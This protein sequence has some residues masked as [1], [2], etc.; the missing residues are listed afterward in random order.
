MLPAALATIASGAA[1][2][3]PVED[4]YHGKTVT[5]YIGTTPGG[6]YDTYARLVA[7]FLGAHIPG[8]PVILPVNMPGA[9]GRTA[10]GH[11]Y[12][13]V[14]KDGLSLGSSDQALPLAQAVGDTTIKFDTSK[15]NWIGSTDSDNK[16]MVAWFTSGVKTIEDARREEVTMGAPAET[17]GPQYLNAMNV[18]A[19]TRFKVITGYPGINETN[20]AMERGEVE[21][22]GGTSWATWKTKPDM[23]RDH[24]I[25]VLVQVGFTKAPELQDV[26]LLMELGSTPE[27]DAVLKLLS[28]PIPIGHPIY[29]SP[30]VPAERVNAL[31]AAFDETMKDPAL[32]EEAKKIKLGIDPT[33]GEKLQQIAAD[34]QSAPQSVKDRLADIILDHK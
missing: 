24:K 31:R 11:I 8:H 2:A 3:D 21:G 15:L 30:G 16:V 25:N 27:A 32:L 28:A 17:T 5:L 9:G 33:P 6:G 18:Y 10:A 20:L 7:R 22:V 14:A 12:S 34:I 26:P 29:T 23:L 13:I 4:F 19:G 1:R